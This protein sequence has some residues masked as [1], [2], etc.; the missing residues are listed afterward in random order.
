MDEQTYY[1]VREAL[2][3]AH[4]A[5]R[6]E[7]QRHYLEWVILNEDTATTDFDA[8]YIYF[9]A[10]AVRKLA[11]NKPPLHVDFS[12]SLH[13]VTTAAAICETRFYDLR[14]A[15]LFIEGLT[16][17]KADLTALDIETRS[18]DSVSCMHVLEHIGLGR[19]GDTPDASGDLKA[20]D[21]LK[22]IVR[23]GG[24]LYVVAPSG[25]PCVVFNAH[26][27]YPVESFDG[28]FADQFD[29]EELYFIKGEPKTAPPLLN[30]SFA[31]TLPY[32]MGCGCYMFRKRS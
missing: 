27:I 19:Y 28:Y 10:W 11:E 6:P 21:E 3:A 2:I 7:F 29:L 9:V 22:R 26:R 20:I 13:F 23:P 32:N 15:E 8:H 17:L 12:S 16:C 1:A 14:P 18:L 25:K 5:Q 31:E 4:T 24:R 30:P